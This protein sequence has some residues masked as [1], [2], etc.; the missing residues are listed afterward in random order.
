MFPLPDGRGSYGAFPFVTNVV[1]SSRD[2][3]GT[4]QPTAPAVRAA[5]SGFVTGKMSVLLSHGHDAR[6]TQMQQAPAWST[7]A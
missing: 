1:A 7:G 4:P 6:A 5:F 2:G 3:V